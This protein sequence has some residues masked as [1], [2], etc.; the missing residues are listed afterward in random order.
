MAS[1]AGRLACGLAAL[2]W[3]LGASGV[4][5]ATGGELGK[6]SYARVHFEQNATD[7][8]VE[9]VFKAKS[10]KG[11]LA[12]LTVVSPDGRTVID[13][14]APDPSTLG[15]R[16]F[17]LESPEPTDVAKLKAAYPEGVY[18]FTGETVSGK[19]LAGESSLSHALPATTGFV[20]PKEQ[21]EGVSTAGLEIRWTQVAGVSAYLIEIE[22]DDL[23][24]GFEATLPGSASAFRVPEG[25]LAP[26]TEYDL[27]LGTVSA[28]GNISFVETSFSTAE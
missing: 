27:S 12:K 28:K 21:A 22:N 13:F 20:H 9:V 24:V 18:H 16:Q 15:M 11:G 10:R 25:F 1:A 2:T 4:A 3:L 7:G 5:M 8:D 23:D 6:F 26:G 14:T 19:K 17:A